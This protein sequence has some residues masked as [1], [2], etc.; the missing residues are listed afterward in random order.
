MSNIYYQRPNNSDKKNGT[1]YTG[2]YHPNYQM[3]QYNPSNKIVPHPQGYKKDLIANIILVLL[4]ITLVILFMALFSELRFLNNSYERKASS[5]WWDYDSG[6][7]VDSI[8]CRYENQFRGV[9]ETP[10]LTQCYAVSEYF[11][12]ASLYKAAVFTGNTEKEKKYL[13]I[14][15][16][17]YSEMGDV[18]Y[19]AEDIDTKLGITDLLK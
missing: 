7:Y 19:L 17:A 12:A 16:K 14:M 8:R 3:P 18:S 11:E 4:S 5:F 10:E 15:I 6:R 13:E 9:E 1:E 2:Y